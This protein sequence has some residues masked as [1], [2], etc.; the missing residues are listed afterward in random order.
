MVQVPPQLRTARSVTIVIPVDS[1]TTSAVPSTLTTSASP[2]SVPAE[3]TSTSAVSSVPSSSSLAPTSIVPTGTD[4]RTAVVI[5]TSLTYAP[6]SSSPSSSAQI[7]TQSGTSTAASSGLPSQ[8]P[9]LVQPP[10]GM[11]HAAPN[12]TLIQIGFNYELN[13]PFV[14]NSNNATAQVFAYLP[15]GIAYGLGISS[16]EV[17]MNALL[18]YDTSKR[19][20]FI[21][22]LAQAYVPSD[23]V[24]DLGSALITPVGPFYQNPDNTVATL[25]NMINPMIPLIP[26]ASVDSDSPSSAEN[27]AA[28]TSGSTGDGAPIGG[29]SGSSQQ[30]QGKS[31]G[32]GVGAVAGA[33]IYAA[34]MVYVARRYRQK[35]KNHQRASSIP[36]AGEM[37]QTSGGGMGGYF[38]SGANGRGSPSASGGRGSRNSAGSGGGRSVREQGIS[39]PI[40]AE[41]SLGWN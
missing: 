27:P 13:Y 35:R 15:Q 7:A 20:G 18:P 30:V 3:A 2:Y 10:G 26:G 23:K 33:A 38:M 8:M 22:T 12:T 14:V 40:M 34:A 39:H 5:P 9:R 21:T 37:S 31:V 1:A 16:R 29:D 4:T 36:T 25:M 19:H 41:N 17:K 24:T 32:I 11:P 6:A 28:T